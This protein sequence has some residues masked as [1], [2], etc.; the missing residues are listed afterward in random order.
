VNKRDCE[1]TSHTRAYSERFW[2]GWLLCSQGLAPDLPI[3]LFPVCWPST[4]HLHVSQAGVTW[5][6]M[7]LAQADNTGCLPDGA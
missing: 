5:T 1:T 3:V 2:R 6:M 7:A 4:Q